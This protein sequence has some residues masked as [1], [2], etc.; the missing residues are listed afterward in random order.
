MK[1][2]E[3]PRRYVACAKDL[4]RQICFKRKLKKY[5]PILIYQMGK[6]GSTS[7]YKSLLQYY[8]GVV[9]H[10]HGFSQDYDNPDTRVLYDWVMSQKNEMKIVSLVREPVARNISSFFQNFERYVGVPF[11]YSNYLI[12]ELGEIFLKNHNHEIPLQWFDRH[13]KNKFGIDVYSSKFSEN[14]V[15]EY[16][17]KNIKLLV[18]RLESDDDVIVKAI[19]Q[20]VGLNK[21]KMI[22]ENIGDHKQYSGTYLEF[23]EKF[24]FP[25]EYISTMYESEYFKYFYSKEFAVSFAKRWSRG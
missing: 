13:I 18:V 16:R 12:E 1:C 20:F 19:Q 14:G 11:E 17:N 2:L 15:G 7:V 22:N 24:K 10:T 5:T 3:I 8:Q 9:I 21:F 4:K 23:K 25:M 6:V